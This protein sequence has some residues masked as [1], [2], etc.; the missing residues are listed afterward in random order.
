LLQ[1]AIVERE[2]ESEEKHA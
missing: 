2:K 1:S